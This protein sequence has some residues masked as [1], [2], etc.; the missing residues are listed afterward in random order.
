MV[1]VDAGRFQVG[2]MKDGSS[3]VYPKI[4]NLR[5]RPKLTVSATSIHPNGVEIEIHRGSSAGARL[6]KMS[7]KPSSG[8]RGDSLQ[9][10]TLD[11]VRDTDDLC[12]FFKGGPGELIRLN[13]LKFS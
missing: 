10:V 3:L 9:T 11:G 6:A 8:N 13:S 2:D 4:R 1:E 12:L 5:Q 7:F